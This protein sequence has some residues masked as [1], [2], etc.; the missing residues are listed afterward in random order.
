MGLDK[1]PGLDKLYPKSSSKN[2]DAFA[3]KH[4]SSE[5]PNPNKNNN[6]PKTIEIRTTHHIIALSKTIFILSV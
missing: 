6:G 5:T 3:R 1:C 4:K 2:G